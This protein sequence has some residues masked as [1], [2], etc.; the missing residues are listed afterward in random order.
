M[1]MEACP[2]Y[3]NGEHGWVDW[4]DSEGINTD[5]V[6]VRMCS[7]CGL[8]QLWGGAGEW[9]DAGYSSRPD[10]EFAWIERRGFML[11]CT[12]CY[13]DG[14]LAEWIPFMRLHSQCLEGCTSC[15]FPLGV[16]PSCQFCGVNNV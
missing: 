8:R 9:Y 10:H 11:K 13:A 2:L 3:E 1:S 7:G 14:K 12:R 4:P 15:G 5:N 16:A 6:D